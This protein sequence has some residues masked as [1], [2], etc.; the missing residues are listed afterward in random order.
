MAAPASS[1]KKRTKTFTGCWT[2]RGRKLKC[3]E[4]TPT[5]QQCA[6]KGLECGGYGVSLQWLPSETGSPDASLPPVP[7]TTYV[8]D[9]AEIDRILSRI[10][11]DAEQPF[12][13][14]KAET[15]IVRGPFAVFRTSFS[16]S[17]R[18]T[19]SLSPSPCTAEELRPDDLGSANA[20]TSLLNRTAPAFH[21]HNLPPDQPQG[22]DD[23][24]S[25]IEDILD[26]SNHTWTP[27]QSPTTQRNPQSQS[28]SPRFRTTSLQ[29]VLDWSPPKDT[30]FYEDDEIETVFSLSWSKPRSTFLSPDD[31]F[32]LN[33][34]IHKVL[35]IFCIVDNAKS[36]WRTLHLP[37]ALQSCGESSA[38]G[39]TSYTRNCLL[40]ALLSTS[41]YSL[42]NNLR[43][44]GR[45]EDVE[46]WSR[47]ALQLRYKAIGLLRDA[48][49]HD[50][51]SKNRPKY[52]ELLATMLSMVTIDVASG[53]TGTCGVHLKGC[54]QLIRSARKSKSR[55]SVKA[56][57]LHR[58]FFYLRTIHAS[59][60]LDKE[61]S[62]QNSEHDNLQGDR[63]ANDDSWLEMHES[64]PKDMTSCDYV[65]G[66]PLSLLVLTRKAIRVVQA[67]A[68]FRQRNPALLFSN[69]LSN[70]CDEVDEG[71]LDWPI[72]KELS[73]CPTIGRGD[74]A[75]RIVHHQ[76]H[77]FHDALVLYFAQ[78]VRLMHH[79][80]L[81]PYVESVLHHLE[82]IE[83]IKDGS[84]VFAGTLFWPA[85]IAASEA[86]DQTL[87][88]RFM[89]WFERAKIYGLHSLWG[90]NSLVLQVWN[91]SSTSKARVTSQWRA[92]AEEKQIELMLS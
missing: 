63:A 35:R 23:Q 62:G 56:R 5:C 33:Y 4:E 64:E 54:E 66:V 42:V 55:Y 83:K 15:T 82:E 37:R 13:D 61:A 45:T 50:L 51:H 29:Q 86:F 57:A 77:A 47:K 71:I 9:N 84:N 41:A 18:T 75:S 89:A 49:E 53:D 10:D 69:S 7:P 92:I 60:T 43:L 31:C 30:T 26:I 39:A 27:P 74:D 68:R 80:H 90:G 24:N 11:A 6:N 34:Y 78:H 79:R 36:P 87:Q 38:L 32:L 81:K 28:N 72:D 22:H 14:G 48:V 76:T 46:K 2:C 85:F 1:P 91:K 25:T 58:I 67:V 40:H 8:L 73:Q 70:K 65:Y 20:N 17:N 44:E 3:S 21:A 19:L 88:A 52:K 59:T 12:A 16:S